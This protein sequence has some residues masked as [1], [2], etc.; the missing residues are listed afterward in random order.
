M[1]T[2]PAPAGATPPPTVAAASGRTAGYDVARAVALLGMVLVNFHGRAES[3]TA[4]WWPTDLLFT[5]LEGRS[6]ALFVMLAGVGVSLRTRRARIERG[7]RIAS[8][9]GFL[10]R[11]A[12][13]LFVVGLLNL[14]LWDWDI[15]H[16][17]GL[18]LTVAAL[19][20]AASRWT[21]AGVWLGVYGLA[22]ALRIME[23]EPVDPEI[24]TP[25]GMLQSLVFSGNYPAL[26][27]LCFLLLGMGVGRLDLRKPRV[28][29]R[30]MALSGVAVVLAELSA[31]VA[32][33]LALEAGAEPWVE[34]WLTTWPRPPGPFFV[35]SSSAVAVWTTTVAIEWSEW[36][37]HPRA[38]L[39]LTATGQLAL[40]LYV[41][42][43]VGILIPLEHDLL[44]GA[45]AELILAWGLTFFAASVAGALW[46]RRRN[47]QGPLEAVLRQISNRSQPAWGGALMDS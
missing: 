38:I 32:Q 5:E 28:R 34:Q 21:L 46:W 29:R 18:Y 41:A 7:G 6:A 42:H 44:W 3:E 27:W 36:R 16:V 43:E 23:P 31:R 12:V 2:S 4:L 17:Y 13:A 10:L 8:E 45:P 11:R 40:S 37:R 30:L 47:R 25:L 1:A 20:F 19:L 33:Q 15:L 24:W 39:A 35:L 14:H 9:R 22:V 26:P